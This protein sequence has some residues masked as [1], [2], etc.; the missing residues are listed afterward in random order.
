MWGP[1]RELDWFA[2]LAIIIWA[3]MMIGVIA[4]TFARL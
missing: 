1:L 4:Y 2:W 3:A